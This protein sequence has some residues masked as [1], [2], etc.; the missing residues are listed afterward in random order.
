MAIW[1]NRAAKVVEKVSRLLPLLH[2][3]SRTR[4]IT[5]FTSCTLNFT[6]NFNATFLLICSDDWCI[7]SHGLQLFMI[8]NK[9][10]INTKVYRYITSLFLQ[11][12]YAR[13]ERYLHIP[14][15]QFALQSQHKF[16]LR[17]REPVRQ[18]VDC[19]Y[20]C[21]NS[22]KAHIRVSPVQIITIYLHIGIETVNS[23]GVPAVSV[24]EYTTAIWTWL[25]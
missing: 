8:S 2:V 13:K 3:P 10:N 16:Y 24:L 22:P 4:K 1:Q 20:G 6:E 15:I 25:F 9:N 23:S 5:C 12:V 7:K 18:K 11:N 17:A 21:V 19:A 14:H